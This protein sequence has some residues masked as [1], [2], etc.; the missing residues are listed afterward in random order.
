[1]PER[2]DNHPKE[3]IIVSKQRK[4][5]AMIPARGGSKR[6]PEKNIKLFLGKPI[7]T[8]PIETCEQSGIFGSIIVNSDSKKILKIACEYGSVS[9]FLRV[10]ELAGDQ[11]GT[12][13][14]VLDFISKFGLQSNDVL[15]CIYATNPFL[16]DSTLLQALNV[17]DTHENSDSFDLVTAV[18]SYPFPIQRSMRRVKNSIFEFCDS[19]KIH[20]HSQ[21]LDERFHS[22][23]Q[24]WAGRVETWKKIRAMDERSYGIQIP[25]WRVQ[26]I[27]TMEDWICA[28]KLYLAGI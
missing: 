9:P 20:S 17:I 7:I 16:V 2:T 8:Y 10:P 27:D 1:V 25:R 26:D 23:S 18:T 11:P 28:E 4:V 12:L 5:V 24:F 3:F 13:E 15:F 19:S 22:A 21:E 6:I 14:V